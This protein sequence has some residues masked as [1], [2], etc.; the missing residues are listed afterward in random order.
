MLVNV[1]KAWAQKSATH[2]KQNSKTKN[3]VKFPSGTYTIGTNNE[4]YPTEYPQHKVRLK[5]WWLDK[6]LITVA[7]YESFVKATNY[8]TQAER[9]GNAGVFS[10]VEKGWQMVSLATWHHPAGPNEP[11]A[12]PNHP[13][14]QVSWADAVAYCKWRKKR[15]PTEQEWEAAA[16]FGHS[17]KYSWGNNYSGKA[18]VWSGIFPDTNTVTDGFLTTS[19]VGH[20]G[21]NKNGLSDMGGNVWQ[22]TSSTYKPYPGST[23][24]FDTEALKERVLRGGSFLCDSNV[25]HGYRVTA[26]SSNSPET[27][28]LHMGFRC[29]C[30]DK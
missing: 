28:L 8:K 7:D 24:K 18:N 30:D 5:S 19:P 20:F 2:A 11:A 12:L 21:Y 25:C 26:R 15:L 23:L 29:A 14:T 9:F 17:N 10:F 6:N 27:S 1:D 4:D 3:M 22:W 16:R 13:V